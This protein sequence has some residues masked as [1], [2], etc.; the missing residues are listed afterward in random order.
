VVAELTW[1]TPSVGCPS[2][3]RVQAEPTN[4]GADRSAQS[5]GVGRNW[6]VDSINRKRV[7]CA[8]IRIGGEGPARNEPGCM[9]GPKPRAETRSPPGSEADFPPTTTF[10]PSPKP[11]CPVPNFHCPPSPPMCWR[12]VPGGACTDDFG[13]GG[14]WALAGPTPRGCSPTKPTT[15]PRPILARGILDRPA[16]QRVPTL[17]AGLSAIGIG[18]PG[19]FLPPANAR[20]PQFLTAFLS[21]PQE[22]ARGIRWPKVVFSGGSPRRSPHRALESPPLALALLSTLAPSFLLIAN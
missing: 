17:R 20:N 8:W 5:V 14:H 9:D 15:G 3:A 19:R 12:I 16:R 18:W 10:P 13:R 11:E 1:P 4:L 6:P 21:Y 22:H 2:S 7:G